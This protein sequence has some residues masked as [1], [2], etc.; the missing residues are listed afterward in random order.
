MEFQNKKIE[1]DTWYLID[2]SFFFF[3]IF[4]GSK[5]AS[6]INGNDSEKT[7]NIVQDKTEVSKRRIIDSD[8]S[9]NDSI[10]NMNEIENTLNEL[11]NEIGSQREE[12]NAFQVL[13]NRSK[14]IQYKLL[15]QQSVENIECKEK[16]DDIKQLK[17][18][19]KEKLIALAAKKGYS[20]KK[21]IEVEEGERIE[22]RIEN[23]MRFFKSDVTDD[24]THNKNESIELSLKN[25][26]QSGNLL[27]Y[28]R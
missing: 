23:R 5:F 12:S 14:P 16:L 7:K 3:L 13:M 25:K 26:Q 24:V 27:N 18:K 2:F 10:K 4:K 20:K 28:F 19:R 17:S 21:I 11:C 1:I 8:N 9:L 22:K 15:P 6:E